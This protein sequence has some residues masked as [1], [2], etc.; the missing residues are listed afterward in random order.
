MKKEDTVMENIMKIGK[1]VNMIFL[2]MQELADVFSKGP[3][4]K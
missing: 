3:E 4:S 2:L 1:M